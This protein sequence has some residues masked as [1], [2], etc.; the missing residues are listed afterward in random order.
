MLRNRRDEDATKAMG[1]KDKKS[2]VS[3]AGHEYLF[4]RDTE[5]RRKE[6]FEDAR[7]RCWHCGA[8]YG[9][10]YGEMDHIRS[11]YGPQRCWCFTKSR[12]VNLRWS[13]P[14]CHRERH[15]RYPRLGRIG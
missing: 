1:F 5:T 12:C 9:W 15:G 3:M 14:K 13:C 7:G 10:Y 8:Y 4:G 6:V 11:G 2:F